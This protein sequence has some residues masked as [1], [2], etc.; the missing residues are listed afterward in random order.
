M[1]DSSKKQRNLGKLTGL[2]GHHLPRTRMDSPCLR[3]QTGVWGDWLD[4]SGTSWL[5]ST[6][7]KAIHPGQKC[8]LAAKKEFID[9][10]W[11]CRDSTWKCKTQ[12]EVG[13]ARNIKDKR[14]SYSCF[15]SGKRLNKGNVDPE[16]GR[17]F[18]DSRLKYWAK[19]PP[20]SARWS[21]SP[22]SAR[23]WCSLWHGTFQRGKRRTCSSSEFRSPESLLRRNYWEA[24]QLL[25]YLRSS[26]YCQL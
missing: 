25:T 6:V 21:L 15:L 9:I 11:A 2:W 19:L 20:S 26:I 23:F 12:L 1:R 18:S 7:K 5:S 24:W 3:E 4:L 8:D 14:E 17:E 13:F 10:A 16:W 22:L